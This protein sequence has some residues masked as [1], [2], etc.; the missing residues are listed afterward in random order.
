VRGVLSEVRTALLFLLRRDAERQAA[1]PS[2]AQ[3]V[4]IR[5]HPCAPA[6]ALR[7]SPTKGP[8]DCARGRF[9]AWS[10]RPSAADTKNRPIVPKNVCANPLGGQAAAPAPSALLALPR[11]CE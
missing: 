8:V 4:R 10:V 2:F 1:L 6:A 3:V 11:A 9:V 7:A 5:A